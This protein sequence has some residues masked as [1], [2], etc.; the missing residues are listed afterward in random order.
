MDRPEL[1]V[2]IP[3]YNEAES[4]APL[5][6]ELHEALREMRA[7]VVFVDDGSDDGT[8]QQLADL[9]HQFHQVRVVSHPVNAGQ[10][11]ALTTGIRAADGGLIVTL[12]GDGQ[13]DPA[14]IPVLVQ[15]WRAKAPAHVGLLMIA[16]NRAQRRDNLIRRISSRIANHVRR[17]LLDDDCL[18]TGCSL[19]LFRREDFLLLP[20]FDHMHRFLPALFAR[21]GIAV[22]N[23]PVNHRERE[24]G[25]SKYGVGNRLWVGI[26]D[27]FCVRWLRSRRIRLPANYRHNPDKV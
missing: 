10:S 12:D 25:V 7:E 26:V 24:A 6:R 1:S 3:V 11:A 4:V 14:D 8:D 22:I 15:L 20:Q 23:T 18:D 21:D 5:C 19:K 27:M 17:W 9:K 2:V 13:N 16:G